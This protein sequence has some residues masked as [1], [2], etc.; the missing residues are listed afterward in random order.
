M[1]IVV[2]AGGL[3]PERIVS[4][5][6]GTMACNAFFKAGHQAILLDLFFGMPE[7]AVSIDQLFEQAGPLPPAPISETEPDLDAIA[8]SRPVG[9]SDRIGLNVIEICQQADIV[10]MWR[11]GSIP[12]LIPSCW[13]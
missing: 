3:S 5:S 1:K 13:F 10:Y 11:F 9:W 12:I 4:L 2:L 8:A 7:L 6:S